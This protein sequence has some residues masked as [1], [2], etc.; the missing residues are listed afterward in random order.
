MRLHAVIAPMLA[1][2]VERFPAGRPGDYAY[3]PKLDGFRCLAVIDRDRGV[4]LQSRRGARFNDT[5]PEVVWAVY[6]H[7]PP[8]T[9]VDGEIVRWSPAGRLDFLALQ[10]RNVAGRRA[11]EQ[12]SR[13]QPCHYVVFDVLRLRGREVTAEPLAARRAL[14]EE[15]FRA[16]PAA[17]VLALSMQTTDEREARSWY[18]LLH[19]AGIEGLM[20]KPA[21]S[22]YEP[23]AHGWQKLKYRATAEAV[24]GGMTGKRR[25]PYEL[26]LGR[27][28]RAGRLRVVGRTTRLGAD[29]AAQI[30]PL[31]TPARS[32]HPWPVEL[33]PSWAGAAYGRR[34]PI[35]YTRVEPTLVVYLG[36]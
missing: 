4:Y 10:Q 28:D 34:D 26:L 5:F 15:M 1:R 6:E 12:L 11:A 2:P 36:T 31:L 23:G 32:E 8:G 30:A 16:V 29:M 27:Y 14:L 33:P 9:V 19:T 7:L 24:V 18:S 17:G 20:I 21:R 22:R 13:S 25:R 3:E 35:I